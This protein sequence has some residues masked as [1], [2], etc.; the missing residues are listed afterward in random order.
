MSA[1]APRDDSGPIAGTARQT[2]ETAGKAA[3]PGT[4]TQV[5]RKSREKQ[6]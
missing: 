5:I 6:R 3:A 4:A 1:E 2:A